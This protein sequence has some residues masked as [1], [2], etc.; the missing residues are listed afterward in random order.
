MSAFERHLPEWASPIS[1]I[2][3]GILFGLPGIQLL[4]NLD[5]QGSDHLADPVVNLDRSETVSDDGTRQ[6]DLT[7]RGETRPVVSV[8]VAFSADGHRLLSAS[9]ELTVTV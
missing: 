5:V 4:C 2:G 7:L 6:E 1:L 3:L 8:A 9:Q